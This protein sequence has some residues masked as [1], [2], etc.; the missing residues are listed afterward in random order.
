MGLRTDL[1]RH[2]LHRLVYPIPCSRHVAARPDVRSDVQLIGVA[3]CQPSQFRIG[4]VAARVPRCRLLLQ[5]APTSFK[6]SR[7]AL[8]G[9]VSKAIQVQSRSCSTVTPS[10]WV[11]IDE[12]ALRVDG[13]GRY[14]T[15]S[16]WSTTRFTF[17][18]QSGPRAHPLR[19]T[20]AFRI[21]PSRSTCHVLRCGVTWT[22]CPGVIAGG[23]AQHRIGMPFT[24]LIGK[25]PGQR[26]GQNV[27]SVAGSAG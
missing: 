5:R 8:V 1:P 24:P 23:T 4:H 14:A 17:A 21:S 25:R 27:R 19:P 15:R 7:T 10:A 26:Q 18:L 20:P 9:L 16:M 6:R 12:V 2:T 13:D 22:I 11:A 3:S